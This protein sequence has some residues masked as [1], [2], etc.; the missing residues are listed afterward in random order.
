VKGARQVR[1]KYPGSVSI[2]IMPPSK[3]ELAARLK[4][5]NTDM[6]SEMSVRL[7]E[8]GREMAAA[9]EYD[10]LIVNEDLDKA[11]KELQS[12]IETERKNREK[13]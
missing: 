6:E 12:I 13:K 5:R 4:K 11:V 3:D 8:S 2:F 10:Y 9:E 1:E 7:K